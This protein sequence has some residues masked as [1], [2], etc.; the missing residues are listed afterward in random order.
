MADEALVYTAAEVAKLMGVARTTV[1]DAIRDGRIPV[2]TA[3]GD[4]VLIPKK[5]I[6]EMMEVRAKRDLE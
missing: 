1:Y 2:V 6:H 3:F 5:A 4:R